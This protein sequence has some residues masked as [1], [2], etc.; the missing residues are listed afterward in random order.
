MKHRYFIV[1]LIVLIA[2]IGNLAYGAHALA[3]ASP[4]KIVYNKSMQ[5]RAYHSIG[6]HSKGT[7]WN[8]PYRTVSK[9][10]KI[11]YLKNYPHT[12]WFTFRHMMLHSGKVYWYVRSANGKTSGWV[13]KGYMHKG[14]YMG[15]AI[16]AASGLGTV[17]LPSLP[18]AAAPNPSSDA[19]SAAGTGSVSDQ[20]PNWGLSNDTSSTPASNT[21]S[22]NA[23]TVPNN[24]DPS[25]ASTS[26]T[27][28]DSAST[29]SNN[30]EQDSSSNNLP[31]TTIQR[32]PLDSFNITGD[33]STLY[34]DGP[35]QIISFSYSPKDDSG[36]MD[37]YAKISIQGDSS[38]GY[39]QKNYNITL[40]S[41]AKCS[42]KMKL[43]LKPGW[44]QQSKYTLKANYIDATEAR[45]IVNANIW[46]DIVKTRASMP[47]QLAASPNYGAIDGFPIEVS[48]NNQDSGLY[49][50]NLAKSGDLWAMNDSDPNQ[51][52]V[53]GA[54]WDDAT[55]FSTDT[56]LL[57][58]SDWSVEFPDTASD[59]IKTSFNN[60]LAFVNDS[61]DEDFKQNISQYLDLDSVIDYYLFVNLTNAT[62][63]TGKNM[64]MLTYD[65]QHWLT[66]AY[67]L[68][69]TWDLQWDGQ[70]LQTGGNTFTTTNKLLNRIQQLYPD[71][72]K[73]RWAELE[74][75][76]IVDESAIDNRFYSFMNNI[77]QG[78]Y[79][80]NFSINSGIPSQSLTN[81]V[82]IESAVHSQ[83]E[84][85]DSKFEE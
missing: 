78:N 9:A 1:T 56:A 84:L 2:L 58:G 45:N 82:Q 28:S 36:E 48:I 61:S 51:A 38:A 43:E 74:A 55:Y 30:D 42:K 17:V 18:S 22:D 77:G 32:N 46:A 11:H 59:A 41:D 66:S 47:E 6:S 79:L 31:D 13:Y 83:I 12:T 37:G 16:T 69:T 72:I 34:K 57:D 85:C 25:S 71:Q 68:D 49:T 24:G 35:K 62:D 26:N 15:S 65:G 50:L 53:Q 39:P 19:V 67:D 40:Y 60:M 3:K 73:A 8:H 75:D 29:I 64:M 70:S 76:S 10:R 21:G 81:L 54:F 33:L 14:K 7:L 5:H 20:L 44:G 23:S 80:N 63:N 27:G 4:Y 52:A